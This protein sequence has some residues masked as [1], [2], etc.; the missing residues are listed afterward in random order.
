MIVAP[1]TRAHML[2]L[3]NNAKERNRV[4][5]GTV[6]DGLPAYTMPGRG[7]AIMDHGEVYAATGLAPIW[8]GVAEAWFI[9]SKLLDRRKISVIRVVRKELESAIVRL[10]LR[11]V[12]AVVRS[13]FGDAHK[14]ANWLGFENEGLMRRYGPD[15]F[16]YERY[17]KWPTQ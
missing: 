9:P 3:A 2:H 16:D 6:L 14:L 15:G 7:L 1:L 17:A 8:D 10:K 11:R 13:D 4:M 5:L 12:Q